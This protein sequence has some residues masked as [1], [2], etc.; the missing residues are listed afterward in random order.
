MTDSQPV[1]EKANNLA[2]L[3]IRRSR[4]IAE[5]EMVQAATASVRKTLDNYVLKHDEMN[6][7]YID[8]LGSDDM[9]EVERQR[10]YREWNASFEDSVEMYNRLTDER[11]R[12]HVQETVL[13]RMLLEFDHR[14]KTLK[15]EMDSSTP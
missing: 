6:T 7:E 10:M 4:T 14:I 15:E 9:D 8:K 2:A 13:V 5:L 11:E 12:L 1:D 3:E